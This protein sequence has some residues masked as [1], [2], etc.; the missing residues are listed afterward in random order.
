VHVEGWAMPS[1][2]MRKR[3]RTNR[4]GEYQKPAKVLTVCNRAVAAFGPAMSS[5]YIF[6]ELNLLLVGPCCT[7]RSA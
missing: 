3:E 5:E 2:T 6:C 1:D 4:P 7:S